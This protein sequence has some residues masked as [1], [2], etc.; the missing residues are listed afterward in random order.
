[1]AYYSGNAANFADLKTAIENA[2]V[3]EGWTLTST[4]LFK[5][6]C[7]VQ[8]TATGT[9]RLVMRGGTGR[10]G[11]T[12]T[13]PATNGVKVESIVGDPITFPVAYEIHILTAPDE[14]FVVMNHNADRYQTLAF[15]QSPTPNLPG[16]G[17]WIS[18]GLQEAANV[19]SS[20][21]YGLYF[22]PATGCGT[23]GFSSSSSNQ[24][25][26]MGLFNSTSGN[27][28]VHGQRSTFFHDGLDGGTGWCPTTVSTATYTDDGQSPGM[29]PYGTLY[30]NTPSTAYYT[31]F[32]IPMYGFRNRPSFG[33]SISICVEHARHARLNYH[34]PGD[35]IEFGG[36]QWKLYPHYR[37]D[38]SQPNGANATIFHSGTYGFAVR[39]TGP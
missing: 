11:S 8:F 14:V 1:M 12:L 25:N 28:S 30:T 39:Y 38:L 22:D 21:I 29:M 36:E 9:T 6:S 18:G 31:T 20:A 15:G 27:N 26:A 5:G 19:S 7:N 3:A 17:V 34:D 35:I 16:T 33:I 24:R 23:S 2:C 32:L 10:S 37:R 4:V 13:N